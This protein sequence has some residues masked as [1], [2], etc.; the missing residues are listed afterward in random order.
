M[1]EWH[2][3][4]EI[5]DLQNLKGD[6]GETVGVATRIVLCIV[7]I[8]MQVLCNYGVCMWHAKQGYYCHCLGIRG[9]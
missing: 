2:I 4:I 8:N 9:A 6:G 3:A 7:R 1:V 5:A